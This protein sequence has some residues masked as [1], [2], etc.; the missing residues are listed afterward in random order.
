[1]RYILFLTILTLSSCSVFR[2]SPKTEFRD[3]FYSQKL[4]NKSQE[5]YVNIEN[6][7]LHIYPTKLN[8]DRRII[9]TTEVCQFYQKEIGV[10]FNN[11]T[12]FSKKTLDIDFLTIPLKYR[13]TQKS[14]P[15][16]LNTNLNGAV[17]LGFRTDKYTIDYVD[18]PL[19]KSD[20]NI[21][22]Y[23]FSIGTFVGLGNTIINSTTTNNYLANDYDGIVWTKGVAGIIAVNNFTVGLSVG[24]DNLLDKNRHNWVYESKPWIGLAFGLNLN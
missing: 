16:Q 23:G 12:S 10:G 3:G 9:D 1:M 19:N 8:N 11:I 18:N 21:N 24:I 2:N 14:V 17:Y 13:P 5:V 6:D 22:H 7:V 15:P 20:R 4:D